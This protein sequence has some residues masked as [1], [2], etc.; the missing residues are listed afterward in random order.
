MEEKDVKIRSFKEEVAEKKREIKELKELVEKARMELKVVQDKYE[1]ELRI[2]EFDLQE[3]QKKSAQVQ[4]MLQAEIVHLKTELE[5]LFKQQIM[6]KLQATTRLKPF[7]T[8]TNPSNPMSNRPEEKDSFK[9][10]M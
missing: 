10:G 8:T 9:M 6:Q 7:T 1:E 2:K 3:I 5:K 4:E